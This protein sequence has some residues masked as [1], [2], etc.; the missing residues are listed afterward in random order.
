MQRRL[1]SAFVLLLVSVLMVPAAFSTPVPITNASFES[2]SGEYNYLAGYNTWYN[3]NI[4]GWSHSGTGDWGVWNPAG[5][6]S[7]GVPDGSFIGYLGGGSISQSFDWV[8]AADNMITVMLDLGNRSDKPFPSY[9][10]EL[11][12]GGN[13]LSSLGSVIPGEGAFSTDPELPDRRGQ[14]FSWKQSG[15]PDLLPRR[16]RRAAE[17]R[18]S[19]G[20]QRPP[21]AHQPGAGTGH[22]G[23][24]RR[25][26]CDAGRMRP[27]EALQI[28]GKKQPS[29]E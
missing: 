13:V 12:A 1:V 17:F 24:A 5:Q 2:S 26:P 25:R 19:A 27:Q 29:L 11:L 8:A 23:S 9:S 22:D 3:G 6:Y 15:D 21:P 4:T 16:R 10:V 28:G 7:A 14:S 18:Q 20:Q